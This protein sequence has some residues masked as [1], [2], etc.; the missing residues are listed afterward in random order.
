MR[1]FCGYFSEHA[2]HRD[3]FKEI[4]TGCLSLVPLNDI[5]SPHHLSY[6]QFRYAPQIYLTVPDQGFRIFMYTFKVDCSV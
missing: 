4:Y 6:T 1:P 3:F 5:E 2:I